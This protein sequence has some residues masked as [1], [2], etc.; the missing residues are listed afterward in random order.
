MNNYKHLIINWYNKN[1]RNLPWRGT[2]NPYDVFLSEF[3]LQ[4]TRIEQGK[5]FFLR[6]KQAFPSI[7][8]LAAA[9]EEEILLFWQGLGYYS[10]A[11]NMHASAKMIVEQYQG[12]IPDQFENLK[13][14]KGIG[15]YT[16]AAIASIGFN[17]P[18][19]LMDGNV[20]RVVSRIFGI[21]TPIDTNAGKQEV[22]NQLILFFD[23]EHAG[24]FNE[25]M[26]DFGAIQCTPSHPNCSVCPF[27]ECCKAHLTDNVDGF[28]VKQKK[29]PL[30]TRYLNFLIL[31]SNQQPATVVLNQRINKDIWKN[32]Y[33]F[34]LIETDKKI[35]DSQLMQS[36]FW[37]SLSLLTEE[38][39]FLSVVRK[40]QKLTHRSLQV[41]F[42]FASIDSQ[43]ILLPS[44]YFLINVEDIHQKPFPIMLSKLIE[45]WLNHEQHSK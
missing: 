6:L 23:F 27:C 39:D 28:P 35:N 36:D 32:L 18:V 45:E 24:Q 25:A 15:E 19:P 14:L 20:F 31:Y 43:K 7:N 22:Y 44:K 4:Q 2:N 30:K 11:R 38:P 33:E 17:Q 21:A 41:S 26:M 13:K 37:S 16:A 10:R 12:N 3:I 40:A 42:T 9:S 29:V 8:Q 1:K 34:P 5:P